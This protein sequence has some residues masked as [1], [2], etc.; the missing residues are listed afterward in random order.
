MSVSGAETESSAVISETHVE[1]DT[2]KAPV[3][4]ATKIARP[5]DN[6]AKKAKS[7]A[8]KVPKIPSSTPGR[9]LKMTFRKTTAPVKETNVAANPAPSDPAEAKAVTDAPIP[10]RKRYTKSVTKVTQHNCSQCDKIFKTKGELH[11]HLYIHK[12]KPDLTCPVCS[13]NF[14]SE[15]ESK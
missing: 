8:L 4:T 5:P 1:K 6:S 11:R 15:C 14:T 9:G 7:S 10:A 12:E 3:K 2:E 13:K